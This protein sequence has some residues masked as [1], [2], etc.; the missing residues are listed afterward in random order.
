M[1]WIVSTPD[2]AL[3]AS[4]SGELAEGEAE[5][6]IDRN[7]HRVLVIESVPDFQDFAY[8]DLLRPYMAVL[9]HN[10]LLEGWAVDTYAVARLALSIQSWTQGRVYGFSVGEVRVKSRFQGLGYEQGL[11][12]RLSA[13]ANV[14]VAASLNPTGDGW[15]MQQGVW[16]RL[17]PAMTHHV[18]PAA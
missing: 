13:L 15:I 11:V 3:L 7:P 17:N 6:M 4:F 8:S 2:G 16:T 14:S 18:F 10:G 5:A 12:R 1:T 9:G